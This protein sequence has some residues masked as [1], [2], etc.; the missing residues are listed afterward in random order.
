[1]MVTVTVGSCLVSPPCN[2]PQLEIGCN[3][4]SSQRPQGLSVL[5]YHN[6][7]YP[8]SSQHLPSQFRKPTSA[9]L[10]F[11]TVSDFTKEPSESTEYPFNLPSP[12]SI[13][14]H[15]LT[16]KYYL[17]TISSYISLSPIL[18][19]KRLS[20]QHLPPLRVNP[21]YHSQLPYLRLK[22]F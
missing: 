8:T 16:L 10:F 20:Y 21:F 13:I 5:N 1:M 15:H 17:I 19:E 11:F 14:Y 7:G 9:Y 22:Q 6:Q 18:A 12:I 3:T 4:R 2:L